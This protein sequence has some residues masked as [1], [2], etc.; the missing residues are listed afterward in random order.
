MRSAW[1]SKGLR[2]M[3]TARNRVICSFAHLKNEQMQSV[4]QAACA[5]GLG[6]HS[7]LTRTY[8]HSL[9]HKITQSTCLIS[10]SMPVSSILS[11]V[12]F[13]ITNAISRIN[14]HEENSKTEINPGTR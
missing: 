4:L 13:F 10:G 1:G 11:T 14:Y 12:K 8:S 9:I 7:G 5:L 2:H 3:E 6:R